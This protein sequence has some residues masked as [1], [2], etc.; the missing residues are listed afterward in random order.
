M[1]G[2]HDGQQVPPIA[3][4]APVGGDAQS[5]SSNEPK[6]VQT[7]E[8][9]K[10]G[11][12]KC[13][14][15]GSTEISLSVANG[16]LRCGFCRH[17]FE[18]EKFV[19]AETDISQLQGEIIGSGAQNIVPDVSDIVTFKCSSCGAEVIIDTAEA[20]SARCHWCRNTLSVNQQI[21]NGAV[22]DKVLP[23]AITKDVARAEIEQFVNKRSFF[24]NT[25]FK[26]EF[27]T[28]NVM[29]VYLPYM[30]VDV[31]AHANLVGQG[32]RLVRSYTVGTGRNRRTLYDADL[33]AVQR[34]FDIAIDGMTIES[35]SEK[36]KDKSGGRT[37]NIIN[38][39]MPFDTENCVR[40]DA[41]YLKG[42]TSE[43]RDVD[44]D[45][46]R[47]FV[48]TKAKDVARHKTNETLKQYNRGVAWSGERLDIK[49]QQWKAAY[50]PVWLYS[51]QQVKSSGEKLLHYVAVNAR[52]KETMGSVPVNKPKLF[53]IASIIGVITFFIALFT[54][55]FV[56][57]DSIE[58]VWLLLLAGPIFYGATYNRY[59]NLT[60][61]HRHESNTNAQ[62]SNLQVIDNFIQKRTRLRSPR[63]EGANNT[64][65]NYKRGAPKKANFL[66]SMLRIE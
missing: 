36:L 39:I 1:Q 9:A 14:R 44:I 40:W 28:E 6:I 13:P 53:L 63:M 46:L 10:D 57:A 35:N 50:L 49:G 2:A 4:V 16:K 45:D 26:E 51:Y 37:N 15:C 64:K 60:A 12:N 41:N 29:G 32:E 52:T 11:Q 27:T 3:T 55:L 66:N 65:V 31:N 33:Y 23:F 21:P 43:K 7:D 56:D 48:N 24:A 25:K 62:M 18:P 34:E 61:R 47:G 8:G 20:T 58:V 59:R 30:V 17:E 22:P 38:A 54:A 19:K 42:Y 5:P